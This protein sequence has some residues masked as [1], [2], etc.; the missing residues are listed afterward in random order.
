MDLSELV[1]REVPFQFVF[2]EYTLNGVFFKYKI[3]PQYLATLRKMEDEGTP[4]D[5]VGYRIL[6][7]SIKSWDMNKGGEHFP[8]TPENLSEL[9]VVYLIALGKHIGELRDGN[10]TQESSPST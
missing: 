6:A 4:P 8:P 5:Q 10:P 7:D 2:D 3:S 1:N 9:P